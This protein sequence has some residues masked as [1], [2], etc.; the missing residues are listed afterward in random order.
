M[1]KEEVDR[2]I[3]LRRTLGYKLR[4]A[5]RHL[6]A[7]ARYADE[8]GETHVWTAT[9]LAWVTTAGRTQDA[10]AERMRNLLLFARFPE[11]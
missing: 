6:Q 1:L 8:R 10:R 5:A 9:V 11:R 3:A 4:K 2:Y 7:F